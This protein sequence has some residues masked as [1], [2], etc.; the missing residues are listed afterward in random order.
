MSEPVTITVPEISDPELKAIG[1]CLQLLD[2]FSDI[3][4]YRIITYIMRRYASEIMKGAKELPE[5]AH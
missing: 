5:G 3:E 1:M 4:K 2:P